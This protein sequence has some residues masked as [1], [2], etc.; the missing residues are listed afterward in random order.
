[1]ELIDALNRFDEF[2]DLGREK[3]QQ[4]LGHHSGLRLD[5]VGG[6]EHLDDAAFEKVKEGPIGL[7]DANG[8]PTISSPPERG[9]SPIDL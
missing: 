8:N 5:D 9:V 4:L 6:A 7:L 2:L 1:M 3:C